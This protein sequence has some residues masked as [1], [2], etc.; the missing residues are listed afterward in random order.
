[1]QGAQFCLIQ[2][3]LHLYALIHVSETSI[4][5]YQSPYRPINLAIMQS[6]QMNN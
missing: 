2:L 6:S 5:F 4:V 3:Y 1:M